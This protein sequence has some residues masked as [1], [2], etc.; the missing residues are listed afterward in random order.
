MSEVSD[1]ILARVLGQEIRRARE[2]RGWTRAELAERLPSG[3]VERTLLSYEHGVRALSVAR[4]IEICRTLG[5]AAAEILDNTL[6][7]ARD[8]R[9]F[10][11]KIDLRALLRDERAEFEPVRL[12]ARNR[13]N[14]DPSTE[15]LLTPVTVREM[16]SMVGVSHATLASYL[17][18][19]AS[20]DL[21][22][23]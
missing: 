14:D 15:V 6:E 17:V 3:I 4:F 20:G 23:D 5:V 13:L 16:A 2:G 7:K 19:F 8:L 9:V 11:F 18:N 10:S 21:S 12:W 22:R 1:R